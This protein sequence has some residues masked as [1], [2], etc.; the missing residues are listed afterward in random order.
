M[1]EVQPA[2]G[3]QP[4]QGTPLTQEQLMAL[5]ALAGNINVQITLPSGTAYNL[6]VAVPTSAAETYTFVLTETPSGGEAQTLADF[7]FKDQNNFSVAVNIPTI[8]VSGTKITGGFNLV[9][10]SP[11]Q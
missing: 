5:A 11:Q 10:G 1:S 3:G 6:T 4:V 7:A 9:N 8:D 2:A